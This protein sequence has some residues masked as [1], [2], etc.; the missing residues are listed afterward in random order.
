VIRERT[1]K[2]PFLP[3]GEKKGPGHRGKMVVGK[4]RHR[5]HRRLRNHQLGGGK[6]L[7][8]RYVEQKAGGPDA[9]TVEKKGTGGGGTRLK[10]LE[11]LEV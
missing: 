7:M 1:G 4:V 5:K 10:D 8:L 2:E 3:N 9:Y 6:M 11:M